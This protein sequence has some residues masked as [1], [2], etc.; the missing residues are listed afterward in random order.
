MVRWNDPKDLL[1]AGMGGPSAQETSKPA[2][3][4]GTADVLKALVPGQLAKKVTGTT[5]SKLQA[6]MKGLKK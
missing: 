3:P 2:K 1:K 4:A 5:T 6:V